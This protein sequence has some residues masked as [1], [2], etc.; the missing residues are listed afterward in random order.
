M[1]KVD[2]PPQPCH[3]CHRPVVLAGL[4]GGRQWVHLGTLRAQCGP[5]NWVRAA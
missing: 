3:R 1:L 4:N 5:P 2:S